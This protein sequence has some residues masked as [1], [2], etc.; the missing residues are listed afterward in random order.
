M[1]HPR[2]FW[3]QDQGA[4]VDENWIN[5]PTRLV[6]EIEHHLLS[7]GGDENADFGLPCIWFDA[8]ARNCRHHEHRPQVC[9]DLS[10][11]SEACLLSRHQHGI[12]GNRHQ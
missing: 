3:N 6:T 9:R 8:E 1:G 11:G 2:F 10:C 4:I 12:V 7:L 5:L